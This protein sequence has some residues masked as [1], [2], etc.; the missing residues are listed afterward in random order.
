VGGD[1]ALL[2]ALQLGKVLILTG[3]AAEGHPLVMRCVALL[4]RDPLARAG[5]IAQCAPA[6]MTVEEHA[7][8][9]RLL[10]GVIHAARE[11]T[12][13]GLLP[14]ALGARAELDTRL[15]RWMSAYADGL[16]A[17][18]LAREAGQEG[19]LSY[20][21]ARLARLEAAQGREEPCRAHVAEALE[22]A[23]ALAFGS[24]PPF[25]HAAIGLLELGLGRADEAAE[26]LALSG[27]LVE[28]CGAVDPARLDWAPD[29]IES[30]VRAGRLDDAHAALERYRS[31]TRCTIATWPHATAARCAGLIAGEGDFADH[32]E[33]VLA[34]HAETAVPFEEARTELAYGELLR[35]YR[36][37]VDARVHLRAALTTF[38]RLG[39][40]PWSDRARAELRAT[41]E[42]V[43]SSDARL[44]DE[45]TSQELQVA[46]IVAKGATNKEAGAALFL[47]PKTIEFH[48][49]KVYR[50]LGIHSRGELAARLRENDVA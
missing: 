36:R 32:F 14:Y 34:L 1:D 39:A 3:K 21:L 47:T 38:D 42:T 46:L 17:V 29:L 5:E 41:G 12:A 19:Q 24:T 50:K 40:A 6:L 7:T 18:H 4:D 26:H 10:A 25:A 8:A 9:D 13:L 23:G 49:A 48:L 11:R 45:L 44:A 16:E 15:G 43:H 37:R 31:R 22:L 28:E 20:N 35:R 27:E 2:A 33:E 30:H